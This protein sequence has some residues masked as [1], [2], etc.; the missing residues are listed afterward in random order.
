MVERKPDF[1][2]EDVGIQAFHIRRGQA[3]EK[4]LAKIRQG[5]G[6][7]FYKLSK[8]EIALLEWV[9]GEM[10]SLVGFYEWEELR[11]S[12]LSFEKVES[13]INCGKQVLSHEK[14]GADGFSEAL[15]IIKAGDVE[16]S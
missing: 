9:L 14:L 6:K 13:I 12:L 11:F 1:T 10:W 3:V 8:D 2:D 7:D 4:A 16:Q 5:L 15:E